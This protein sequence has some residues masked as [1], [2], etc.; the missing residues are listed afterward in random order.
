M[1]QSSGGPTVVIRAGDAR[2]FV[3]EGRRGRVVITTAYC[4]PRLPA[5]PEPSSDDGSGPSYMPLLGPLG[6]ELGAPSICIFMDLVADVAVLAAPDGRRFPEAVDAY[7]AFVMSVEPLPIARSEVARPEPAPA[8]VLSLDGQWIEVTVSR[9]GPWLRVEDEGVIKDGM[10]GSPIV[11]LKGEAIGLV[12]TGGLNPVL[13]EALPRRL[14][15][16]PGGG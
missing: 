5:H 12:S 4:L 10:W 2:G 11:N 8:G 15:L 7:A 9:N 6:G 13:T 16:L 14:G 3:V 1:S